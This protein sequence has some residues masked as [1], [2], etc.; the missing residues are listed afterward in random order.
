MSGE[1]HQELKLYNQ[2]TYI[3]T[4]SHQLTIAKHPQ[5]DVE[6][7]EL[8]ANT[9]PISMDGYSKFNFDFL[10]LHTRY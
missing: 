6:Q 5:L 3:S 1:T 10:I 8:G 4:T 2:Y 9:G 7:V